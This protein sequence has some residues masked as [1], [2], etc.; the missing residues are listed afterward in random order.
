[1]IQV[2]EVVTGAV[3][4]LGA[5]QWWL[6]RSHGKVC[7]R[8]QAVYEAV[9]AWNQASAKIHENE[10]TVATLLEMMKRNA[11]TEAVVKGLATMNSPFL[12]TQQARDCYKTIAVDL[13]DFYRKVG[14]HMTP[15]EL[16]LEMQRRFG[17]RLLREVC[18]PMEL[19]SNACI[20]IAIEIA[21]EPD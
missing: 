16:F 20:V 17:D 8:V 15:N 3:L 21:K 4:A 1:M 7:S 19:I 11:M 18:I 5:N 13:K 10:R 14:V 9:A 2:G 6:W 12:I